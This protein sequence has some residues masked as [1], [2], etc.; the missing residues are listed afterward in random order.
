MYSRPVAA[1]RTAAQ[2]TG[3]GNKAGGGRDMVNQACKG[4]G[5]VRDG[6]QQDEDKV[7]GSMNAGDAETMSTCQP[8]CRAVAIFG[9][10][11]TLLAIIWPLLGH[12]WP[13]LASGLSGCS[14]HSE[15]PIHGPP[16]R[17]KPLYL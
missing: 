14:K 8:G 12:Y 17:A 4:S 2:R 5:R 3:V 16:T 11:W 15:S 1:L 6:A 10:F 13:L 7:A 9:H